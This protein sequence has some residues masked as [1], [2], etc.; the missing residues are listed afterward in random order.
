MPGPLTAA[1]DYNFDETDYGVDGVTNEDVN[2]SPYGVDVS[3]GIADLS[4]VYDAAIQRL[5]DQRS[6]L[7]SRERL[8]ALLVG[9]GQPTRHGKWQEG[10]SNAAQVLFQQ[11]TAQKTADE[12]R[13]SELERLQNARDIAG[14]RTKA[15]I[16]AAEI[17]ADAAKNKLPKPVDRIQVGA[18]PLTG[19]PQG[20][21][22]QM[23]DGKPMVTM[24][25]IQGA[26]GGE[27][28]DIPTITEPDQAAQHP[29]SPV[30]KT[31]RGLMK[32]PFYKGG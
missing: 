5:K 27:P 14:I 18:N 12:K 20:Y 2:V 13:R 24:I 8:G 23:I 19:D 7:S 6:G 16:R 1:D 26:M 25:P 15:Q 31:P 22:I 29:E 17:R 4:P 11:S 3:S 10:V 21:H 30:V 28:V 9:F 32:N